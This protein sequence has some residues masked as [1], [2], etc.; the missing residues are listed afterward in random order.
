MIKNWKDYV[1]F[2]KSEDAPENNEVKIFYLSMFD[3]AGAISMKLTKIKAELNMNED[4][5]GKWV[6]DQLKTFPIVECENEFALLRAKN[7]VARQSCRAPANVN[8]E[9]VWLYKG[10]ST[11]DT[12]LFVVE[13]D[14][15]FAVLK[16]P[17]FEKYGFVIK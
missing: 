5:V 14:G 16:H 4:E 12:A 9:N 13:Y 6:E 11:T 10:S 3:S 8:Y 2:Y 1:G 15:K 17:H 7:N